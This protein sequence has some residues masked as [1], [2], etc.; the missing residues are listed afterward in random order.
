MVKK[1]FL[2]FCVAW[3]IF[4][5]S[6][7]SIYAEVSPNLSD[8]AEMLNVERI[9]GGGIA[10]LPTPFM[11]SPK[12]SCS[13]QYDNG[14]A[15]TFF[16]NW[17]PGDKNAIYFDPGTCNIP[18]PYPYPFQITGVDFLLY[19][20]SGVDSVQLK[21]R[22]YDMGTSICQGPQA[23]LYISSAYTITTFYPN[24][25]TVNFTDP[26]CVNRPFFFTIEYFSGTTGTI[27]SIAMDS[28]Q[29][30]V[31]T[32]FQWIWYNPYPPAWYEWNRF[33]GNPDPGWLMIKLRGDTYSLP[34][35]TDW[36]WTA[37]NG[38]APSGMPDVSQNQ[39]DWS[40]YDGP[41]S[42]GNCLEWFG[43]STT[44]VWTITSLI[45]SMA[46]YIQTDSSGSVAQN[47][48]MG[49]V[50][51]FNNYQIDWIYPTTWQKPNFYVMQDSLEAGQNI[52]LLLGFWWSDS[53]NWFREGGHF[54]TMAGV[55]S[56]GLKIATSDPKRDAAEYGWPGRVRP[57]Y[58]PSPPHGDSLH[59]DPL[60][61]SHDIY[62]CNLQS[63][64]PGNHD[65]GLSNYLEF[66][67]EFPRQVT[68]QNF[69]SEFVSYYQPAPPGTN[70]VTEVEYAIMI[71]P[72]KEHW[73]WEPF[74]GD[75]APSGMPD[76]DQK[77]DGWIN[78][79]TGHWSFCG[80]VALA[81]CFWWF[82]SKHNLPPGV[83]GDS[84]DA[85]PLVRD[86]LDENP[87]FI[88]VDDHDM[89]NLNHAG[90]SWFPGGSPP[91]TF[92]PF[93]PGPQPSIPAWGELAERL[94]WE[95]DT[96]GYK[97]GITHGGTKVGDIGGAINRWLS[98]E[99]FLNGSSLSDTLCGRTWRMP[100]FSTVTFWVRNDFG[101]VLLLGFWYWDGGNW[102]RV[103]G[104][105]VTVSG[106][107]SVQSMI[108][109]SDPFF[110]NA[111]SDSSG[112]VL[113][114]AYIPHTPV[115]HTDSTIHN[116]AGN[117]SHDIYAVNLDS[118]TPGGS[119][120]IVDYPV[121]TDPVNFMEIFHQ[122]NVPD[123]FEPVTHSY[124]PGYPIHTVVEYAVEVR[125]MDYR[126]DVNIPGGDG[127]V[128]SADIAFLINYLFVGGPAPNP[129]SEGDAN[130]DGIINSADVSF[131][132]NYLFI[133]GPV[134]R[135]CIQ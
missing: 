94:G 105:Y 75:Y 63:P 125:P 15:L 106:I 28:Q 51:F 21:F 40:A 135:C 14:V 37:D 104:H 128:N 114:G 96:D 132:I 115:P 11:A 68:G 58:H 34:C 121:S 69:P 131:L 90:T 5:F 84:T 107:N 29:D 1:K 79:Q 2:T 39:G 62:Q 33:W 91:P 42:I 129:S 19:N 76:F 86:Y 38:D 48:Q 89:W 25:A 72:K 26:I 71:C 70:Y 36:F 4:L 45:D 117:V 81:D 53:V 16:P 93:V 27:P 50:N 74:F 66:D 10:P 7:L 112:R 97:S 102:W 43:V 30:L 85:F 118:L 67:P 44:L 78:P 88:R 18:Y 59:N 32:C 41:A 17:N 123:E 31:D 60:Y 127:H 134:S 113:N 13:F 35:E 130:C 101:V 110:D 47:I 133:G 20:N 6:L 56:Q 77:Q 87:A 64:S 116:D 95:M 73:Y 126:G 99:T 100:T 109:F 12:E 52:I 9:P 83:P 23:S 92:Q 82:D 61:V 49:L 124:L 57:S 122:Q 119:W 22:V 65:F 24:W 54:V 8:P 3:G 98:S 111:E 120:E 80:P 103:G 55:K 46:E 108:A